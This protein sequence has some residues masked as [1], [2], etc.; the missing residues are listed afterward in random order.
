MNRNDSRT[1]SHAASGGLG[2][3]CVAAAAWTLSVVAAR[4]PRVVSAAVGRALGATLYRVL[5]SRRAVTKDNLRHAFPGESDGGLDA[6]ARE[7][8]RHVGMNAVELL[9][10]HRWVTR[11]APHIRVE[12]MDALDAFS[13]QGVGVVVFIPHTGNWELLAPLWPSLH[14]D[15]MVLAH[16]LA[17][18]ALERLVARRRRVTGLDIRPR[19]G[20]LR[21]SLTGLRSGRAVGLLADQ[22]AGA[23]GVFVSFFGRLASCEASPAALARHTNSPIV[24]CAAFRET[25][26]SHRVILEVIP[27]VVGANP[28]EGDAATLARIYSRLEDLIREYPAQWLWMHRRWKTRAPEAAASESSR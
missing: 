10:F 25:D 12:G 13:E 16:P 3:L 11:H 18:P 22:D 9:T 19:Q 2:D 6:L 8:F 28:D 24:L 17:N 5:Q 21:P 27:R 23:G 15:P 4:L 20:G 26:G 14:P 7:H 1:P